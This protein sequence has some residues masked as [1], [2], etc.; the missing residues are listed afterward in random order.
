MKVLED[1]RGQKKSYV[2]NYILLEG[3]FKW[4]LQKIVHP[5]ISLLLIHFSSFFCVDFRDKLSYNLL[6]FL[7]NVKGFYGLLH[8]LSTSQESP[9]KEKPRKENKKGIIF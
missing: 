2:R 1:S 7:M 6:P 3:V 4:L 9:M 5:S 8:I